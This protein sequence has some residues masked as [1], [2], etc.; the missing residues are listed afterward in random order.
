MRF[1]GRPRT[2]CT[3]GAAQRFP[4]NSQSGGARPARR[5]HGPEV[6]HGSDTPRS[7]AVRRCEGVYVTYSPTPPA[8][9]PVATHG[10]LKVVGTR[11]QDQSGASVQLKGISSF[12]LNWENPKY[13]ESK[14]AVQ[15]MRDNWKIQVIRGSM[16]IDADGG[17]LTS[18]AAKS[19]MQSRMDTI[20]QN[21]LSLG[22]YVILDWH[23]ERAVDQTNESVAFFTG[24][25]DKYGACPN[26][27]YEDYNEPTEVTWDQ[28]KSYHETVVA[29]IRAKD[30][31]NLIILGTP[32][33]SSGVDKAAAS[34]VSGTNLLYT[35]HF[36]SCTHNASSR[37]VGDAAMAKGL[38]L[39]ITEFGVTPSDGGVPPNNKVCEAEANQWWD[40]MEN[41]G[42][43]GTAWK[44]VSGTDSSNIFSSSSNPPADG[45]FPDSVLSQTSGSSPGHGQIV[46]DWLRK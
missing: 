18:A 15:Y 41:N 29:A 33:W 6:A 30:P 2:R 38:A 40:W 31:D 4:T 35:L 24:M 1:A 16:G 9:S 22:L 32:D 34:P 21:A 28:I 23:T 14:A 39:F 5:V 36:Y 8:G 46:V 11:I 12:W 26:L 10:Q 27:I 45:P 44:L 20:V 25:A 43:S 3:S 42:I 7:E 19:D 17:Y 13:A 37:A